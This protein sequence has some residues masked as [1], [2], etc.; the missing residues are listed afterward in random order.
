[1]LLDREMLLEYSSARTRE[2]SLSRPEE[3][4][5]AQAHPG[6]WAFYLQEAMSQTSGNHI[7]SVRTDRC[8]MKACR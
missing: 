7:P 2:P 1:M 3:R 4:E 8:T 6:S 5:R